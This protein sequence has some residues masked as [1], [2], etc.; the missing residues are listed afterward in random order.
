[1]AFNENAALATIGHFFAEHY[2]GAPD[3]EGV[4]DEIQELIERCV[5]ERNGIVTAQSCQGVITTAQVFYDRAEQ[6]LELDEERLDKLASM[7]H[8]GLQGD[9]CSAMDAR[10]LQALVVADAIEVA[11]ED[12]LVLERC[13]ADAHVNAIVRRYIAERIN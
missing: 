1:M 8:D 7:V 5:T 6:Y 10:N 11:E 12:G 3:A 4:T 2:D 13:Y 9:V